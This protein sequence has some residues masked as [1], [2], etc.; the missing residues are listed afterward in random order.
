M[1]AIGCGD[2]GVGRVVNK[3][4]EAEED[5]LEEDFEFTL[6]EAPEQVVPSDTVVVMGLKG[7]ATAMAKC[8]N[9]C[10]GMI[11]SATS[12]AAA[13]QPSTVRIARISCE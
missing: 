13:A 5:E 6:M 7:I 3:I 1:S 10:Q 4:A 2:I 11:S 12:P 9:P 8:C